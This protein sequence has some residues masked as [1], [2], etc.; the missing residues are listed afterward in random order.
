MTSET[1]R[2]R[3]LRHVT[4]GPVA[5]GTVLPLAACGGDDDNPPVTPAPQVPVTF[6]H[7]VAS[8][9]PLSDRVVLW[10]RVTPERDA[11]VAVRWEVASDA[12]FATVVRSGTATTST[13]RDHT[14]KVDV[15]GL[16]PAT[17]YHFR[18]AVGSTVSPV[19]RTKTL[20]VGDV[21]AVRLAVFS[22]SNYPAGYF[23][24]YAEAARRDHFDVAVHLGDYIYEYG[25]GGYASD[26]AAALGRLSVP[27]GETLVLA[28]YRR[29]HAQYRTDP[30]LQ[31]LHATL[32]MIAVWD[33]HEI[34]NDTWK[35]G[36]ENHTEGAE[37]VFAERRAAAIQAYHEWMPTRV[38]D[39]ARPDVI[40]R[41]FDFGT[42]LSLHMLDT[43]VIGR[44]QQVD[45]A[46]YLAGLANDPARQLLGTEQQAWLT[47]RLQAS[48]ALW[49]VLG[50]QVLM[51]RM[52][53][54]ASVA[55][56]PG[57]ETMTAYITAV[58][59]PPGARTPQQAAL[60]AQPKLPYNLDAWDGYPA[61]REAVLAAAKAN[62]R[63]LVVLAGDTHN[64]WAADL[65]DASGATV[66]V[67]FATA[68]VSSPGFEAYLPQVPPAQLGAAFPALIDDLVYADTSR[69]GFLELHVARDA[70]RGTWVY[71]DT[72]ARRDY[73]AAEDPTLA[74]R[75]GAG[76]RRLEPGT[77][78]ASLT[79]AGETQPVPAR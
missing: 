48:T 21:D 77:R 22:C 73:T 60:V 35:A 20:P 27:P 54:P 11:E 9:D 4:L 13:A 1:S 75:P 41:S 79:S 3:F 38:A 59:T 47:G 57:V 44:D 50:Q 26:T 74:V 51:A 32:P 69:R 66:G 76:N 24:V 10:T 6:A 45:T 65:T 37:G 16:A 23:N 39:A 61:A 56:N 30:Q 34:T 52:H 7:G 42:L 55:Q 15:A 18:F 67:E 33:D 29:R 14:V 68:S 17:R 70:V 62:D 2:R 5:V 12:Q 25:V 78:P 19:G 49:Q 43:R 40:Y 31:A 71:V 64:A 72:I 53:I 36:A 63:N 46:G 28:D 58:N 8:G